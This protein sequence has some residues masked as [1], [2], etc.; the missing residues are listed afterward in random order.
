MKN[1]SF[2]GLGVMGFPMAGHLF[3]KNNNIN[4]R[5]YN[6]SLEKTQKWKEKFGGEVCMSPAECRFISHRVPLSG[7]YTVIDRYDRYN[8]CICVY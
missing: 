5:V 1:I 3:N 6:R 8:R 7:H 2:I 4:I